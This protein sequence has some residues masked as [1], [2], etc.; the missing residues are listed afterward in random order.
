MAYDQVIDSA[1]V[2]AGLTQI[3]DAIREKS[4]TSDALAFPAAMAE[5]IAAIQ[6]GGSQAMFNG[7]P[8]LCGTFTL[9]NDVTST[10]YLD[11]GV[12]FEANKAYTVFSF[13]VGIYA[14]LYDN[15][16]AKGVI[17]SVSKRFSTNNN[18]R[19]NAVLAFDGYGSATAKAGFGLSKAYD[20]TELV[21]AGSTSYI[22]KAG[23]EYGWIAVE[24]GV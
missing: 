12:A 21:L 6:A 10:K 15:V 19:Y 9:A 14:S 7:K 17:G 16:G 3:A 13:P 2:E 18:G 4:G 11:V 24:D 20:Q 5:A 8:M 1:A 22:Y 23:I